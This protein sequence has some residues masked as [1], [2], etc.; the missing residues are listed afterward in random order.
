MQN[1]GLGT[2]LVIDLFENLPEATI[3]TAV[4]TFGCMLT[5][6]ILAGVW[7]RRPPE[8]VGDEEGSTVRGVRRNDE[9]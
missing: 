5:G 9:E 1:A 6:T 3:P 7:A 8:D 4:Y 2:I